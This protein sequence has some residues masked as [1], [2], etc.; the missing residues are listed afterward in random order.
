MLQ[1]SA[2]RGTQAP[3]PPIPKME[4]GTPG[5][6][7]RQQLR[8][9]ARNR[10][11]EAIAEAKLAAKQA[12]TTAQQGGGQGPVTTPPALPVGNAPQ[13]TSTAPPPDF[14]FGDIPP[15]AADLSMAFFFTVATI[16]IGFPIAR[17]IARRLDRK[18]LV[19][20]AGRTDITPQLR[21]LQDSVDA[22]A[23]E[24]ERISEGQRFTSK[25]LAERAGAVPRQEEHARG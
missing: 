20:Q 1:Q 23:I 19:S 14:T 24:L 15:R 25:L 10:A 2:P 12:R 7:T 3:V 18:S 13:T 17:A 5:A 4:A 9:A 8:D 6:L 11:K 21:Q 16:V 22:M